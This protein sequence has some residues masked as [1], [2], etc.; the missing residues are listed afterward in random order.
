[1]FRELLKRRPKLNTYVMYTTRPPR[2][3]EKEGKAYHFTDEAGIE[4]FRRA[5]KLIESRTYRTVAGPWTYATVDDGQINLSAGDYLMPATLESYRTLKKRF[6][7]DALVPIY[8]DADDGDRLLR[9]VQ[10]ERQQSAP[11]YKEVCRRFLADEA[12]FSET[13]LKEAGIGLHYENDDLETCVGQILDMM[14]KK[15]SQSKE[16]FEL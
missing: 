7:A 10:R 16:P 4:S 8:I 6:G 12:D 13:N 5:G 15:Q 14:D 11:N 9:A 1:M 2:E 3:G